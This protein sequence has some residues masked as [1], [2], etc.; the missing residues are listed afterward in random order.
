MKKRPPEVPGAA[1]VNTVS[2]PKTHCVTSSAP[3]S[4]QYDLTRAIHASLTAT[5]KKPVSLAKIA[6]L[7]DGGDK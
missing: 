7:D 3:S 2:L 5:R 4:P 6:A 1:D